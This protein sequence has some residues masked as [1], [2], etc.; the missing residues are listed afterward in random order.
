MRVRMRIWSAAAS[1]KSLVISIA[2]EEFRCLNNGDIGCSI[3][4]GTA[5]S[6]FLINFV[7]ND[8]IASKG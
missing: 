2:V 8:N 6:L 4:I 5:V 7:W 1:C 3:E